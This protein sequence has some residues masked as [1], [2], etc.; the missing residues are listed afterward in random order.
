ML[1]HV[2][3]RFSVGLVITSKV[4]HWNGPI[5]KQLNG[6]SSVPYVARQHQHIGL[7]GWGNGALSRERAG[8]KFE[9]QV[10]SQL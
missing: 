8:E 1:E 7:M 6:I 10:R 4:N 3:P 9:V 5:S 2:G